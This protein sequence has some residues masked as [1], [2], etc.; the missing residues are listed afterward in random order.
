MCSANSRGR[1]SL[2]LADYVAFTIAAALPNHVIS[3][4]VSIHEA[5]ADMNANG[6]EK[7]PSVKQNG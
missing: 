3:S 7:S 5:L 2:R 6:V 1:K 4:G